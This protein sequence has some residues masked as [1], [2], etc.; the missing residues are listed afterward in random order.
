MIVASYKYIW[1]KALPRKKTRKTIDYI[2][3][4]RSSGGLLGYIN[5]YP[6][7][8]QHVFS[9]LA[10]SVWNETCLDEVSDFLKELK[11]GL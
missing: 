2:I 9:S 11:G 6:P 1:I 4:S 8:R 5:F 7:W 3:E 10:D